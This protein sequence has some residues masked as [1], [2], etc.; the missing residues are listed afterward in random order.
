M[1]FRARRISEVSSRHGV[2][3]SLTHTQ[4]ETG[5]PGRCLVVRR[6]FSSAFLHF[7]QPAQQQ[8][9]WG[10]LNGARPDLVLQRQSHRPTFVLA[11]SCSQ[12]Q[13][14]NNFPGHSVYAYVCHICLHWGGL[15]GQCRH[16]WQS[17]GVSGFHELV[18]SSV[19]LALQ[20]SSECRL[21]DA[22]SYYLVHDG[23]VVVLTCRGQ[24]LERWPFRSSSSDYLL[25]LGCSFHG[26]LGPLGVDLSSPWSHHGAVCGLGPLHPPD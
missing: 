18:Q 2:I 19:A 3:E 20:L 15:G 4:G 8:P 9:W 11:R 17:H 21:C 16:I 26:Y 22:G 5:A 1:R 12:E 23:P 7:F 10:L 24:G 6:L 13:F 25:T 14:A